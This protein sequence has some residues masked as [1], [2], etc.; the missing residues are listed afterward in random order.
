MNAKNPYTLKCFK[1]IKYSN[2]FLLCNYI[3]C[4]DVSYISCHNF[5]IPSPWN[6]FHVTCIG[7]ANTSTHSI[8][9]AFKKQFSP[10]NF[11]GVNAWCSNFMYGGLSA[12]Y[13]PHFINKD[14]L[15]FMKSLTWI[16]KSQPLNKTSKLFW[17]FVNWM[18]TSG[19]TIT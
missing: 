17:G 7:E 5:N 16:W 6:T 14:I 2:F 19:R 12:G 10:L 3:F 8:L 13:M 4:I 11:L 18:R 9:G 15:N 1:K